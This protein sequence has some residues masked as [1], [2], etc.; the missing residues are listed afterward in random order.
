MRQQ[1]AHI[2]FEYEARRIASNVAQAAKINKTDGIIF[3]SIDLHQCQVA[4]IDMAAL[5]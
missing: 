4:K 2:Y 1:L 5:R 3:F